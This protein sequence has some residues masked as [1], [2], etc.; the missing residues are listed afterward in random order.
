MQYKIK[1][2][3]FQISI[4][5]CTGIQTALEATG[6]GQT[7]VILSGNDAQKKKYLGRLI[8]E[9]IVAAYC[10]TEPQAGSDGKRKYFISTNFQKF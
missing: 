10:V 4:L 5:G 1:I 9:P 6:L 8:E 3:K 2:M 7:P